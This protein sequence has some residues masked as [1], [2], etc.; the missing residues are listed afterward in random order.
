MLSKNVTL[1]Y[2]NK[3]DCSKIIW[4]TMNCPLLKNRDIS[5]N[6][7]MKSKK[8][9]MVNL[10]QTYLISILPSLGGKFADK[11]KPPSNRPLRL[12]WIQSSMV[13]LSKT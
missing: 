2:K 1:T 4:H 7:A 3:I 13:L 9:K 11:I 12:S 6:Y 10:Q 5:I 8:L